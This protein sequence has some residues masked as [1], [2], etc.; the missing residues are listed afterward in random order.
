MKNYDVIVIGSGSGMA[1][2]G[3]VSYLAHGMHIHP[4]LPEF[5]LATFGNLREP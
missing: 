4:A 5:I 3:N 2:G 1:I